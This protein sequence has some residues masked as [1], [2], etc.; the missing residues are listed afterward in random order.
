MSRPAD[1]NARG[2]SVLVAATLF[3]VVAVTG[4][5]IA[6]WLPYGQ[7][8]VT[9]SGTHV[10]TGS[11][12]VSFDERPGL[13]AGWHF[14]LAYGEAVWLALVAAVLIGAALEVLLPRGWLLRGLGRGPVSGALFALPSMMC[15]CCTAPIVT[16]MRRRGVGTAAAVAYW[17]GNPVLN[18]AVLVFLALIGP[19]Q[20]VVTRLVAGAAL[21]LVAALLAGRLRAAPAAVPGAPVDSAAPVRRFARALTRFALVLVPEYALVVFTVGALG[22]WVFPL[23][24][25][26]PGSAAVAVVIAVVI[27]VLVVVPTGGEIPVLLGLAA[28]GSSPM[29]LGASLITLPALSLPSML[30]VGRALSWRATVLAAGC[31]V[32]AGLTAG[33][34]LTLLGS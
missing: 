33:A 4:L 5:L 8:I 19:W 11:S 31:V 26:R 25:S 1:V 20:W 24:A 23:G 34:L 6:K 17:L 32:V 18:P 30:M 13:H 21:V 9:L 10:W 14:L 2:R 16:S 7:R 28:A 15:T 3:A 12:L 27:G 29:V 22:P